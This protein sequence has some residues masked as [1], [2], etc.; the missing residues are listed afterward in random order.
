MEIYAHH[1]FYQSVVD[2]DRPTY[3][4][5]ILENDFS[6]L[7]PNTSKLICID[8]MGKMQKDDSFL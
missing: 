2:L 7:Q 6:T 1:M 8:L 4:S 5:S 3:T